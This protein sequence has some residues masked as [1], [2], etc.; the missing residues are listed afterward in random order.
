MPESNIRFS[1]PEENFTLR[2]T[3]LIIQNEK[4]LAA[5]MDFTDCYYTVG[6][7]V[8]AG[9]DGQQSGLAAAGR[10]DHTDKLVVI[11]IQIGAVQS[12][13]LAVAAFINLLNVFDL[14][15]GN[16]ISLF[17]CHEVSLLSKNFRIFSASM[18]ITPMTII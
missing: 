5:K 16:Q 4:L 11:D 9:T 14:N 10:T 17:S 13:G 2:A 12:D 3:A 8:Q 6:G 15:L 18:P 7:G 1:L